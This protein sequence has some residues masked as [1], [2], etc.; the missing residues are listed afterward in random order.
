MEE[1]KPVVGYENLYEVSSFGR[2]RSLTRIQKTRRCIQ[3]WN[4]I[5]LSAYIDTNG[6]KYVG[7]SKNGKKKKTALHVIVLNAFCRE[8]NHGE[9]ALHNDGVRTNC[10]PSNLRWGTYAENYKDSVLHGTDNSGERNGNAILTLENVEWIRDSKQSSI[11]L[12]K[13]FC[14]ASSTIR[15][16]RLR[17][18]WKRK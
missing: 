1:W 3:R 2:I 12:S 5:M 11:E 14:V 9:I 13:V 16:I 8:K 17:Q 18:N 4:G 10:V 7:L 6:Y 15:A